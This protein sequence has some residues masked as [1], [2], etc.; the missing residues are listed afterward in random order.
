MHRRQVVYPS[1]LRLSRGG[2]MVAYQNEGQVG[3]GQE[4]LLYDVRVLLVQGAGTLV[5]QEDGAIVIFQLFF[6]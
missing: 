6:K 5:Y 1:E 2:E 4:A 3:V